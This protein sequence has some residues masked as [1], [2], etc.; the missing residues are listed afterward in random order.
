MRLAALCAGIAMAGLAIG[1]A[2]AACL[3]ANAPDQ[4]AEGRL[5]RVEPAAR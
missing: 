5:S 1:S 2:Q 4:V 3:K